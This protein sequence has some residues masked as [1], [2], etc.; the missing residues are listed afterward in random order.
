MLRKPSFEQ[1][2]T[3]S[4]ASKAYL[5]QNAVARSRANA[6]EICNNVH[7]QFQIVAISAP[8]G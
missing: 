2:K 5:L 8:T 3:S 1:Q 6:T 7:F 4:E